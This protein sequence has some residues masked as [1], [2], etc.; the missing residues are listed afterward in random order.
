VLV[1]DAGISAGR[2]MQGYLYL[3]IDAQRDP[4]TKDP[5]ASQSQTVTGVLE[6]LY[7][8]AVRRR[9]ISIRTTG[10]PRSSL[11]TTYQAAEDFWDSHL[12][13]G[14]RYRYHVDASNEQPY[15]LFSNPRGYETMV[16]LGPETFQMA[17]L[18]RGNDNTLDMR[19]E[20]QEYVA[21]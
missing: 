15:V 10:P 19:I 16:H 13:Q 7:R 17:Q 4:L 6:T 5:R 9:I 12:A 14:L 11:K 2:Q 20:S 3:P 8:A 21:A 18:Q 1:T